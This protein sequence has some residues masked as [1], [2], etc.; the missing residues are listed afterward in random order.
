MS[1]FCQVRSHISTTWLW[2]LVISLHELKYSTFVFYDCSFLFSLHSLMIV[3]HSDHSGFHLP[4]LRSPQAHD[5]HHKVIFKRL[6]SVQLCST[7]FIL[8]FISPLDQWSGFT[9]Y[10][11]HLCIWYLLSMVRLALPTTATSP[12]FWTHFMV[13]TSGNFLWGTY[14]HIKPFRTM[15]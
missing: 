2:Y 4:W 8:Q 7:I 6:W 12:E 14:K 11:F 10:Q 13:L 1:N 3:Y 15:K 9:Q 5:Y